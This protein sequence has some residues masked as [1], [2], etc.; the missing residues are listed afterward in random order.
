[1]TKDK[2]QFLLLVVRAVA[3][4]LICNGCGHTEWIDNRLNLADRLME[5]RPD[6]A[7]LILDEIKDAH[8]NSNRLKARYAL[9]KSMALDKNYIDTTT[10]DILQ[11]AID[12]YLRSGN[13]DEKLR[14]LYYQGRIHDNAGNDDLAMQSYLEASEISD[15]VTDSL[16]LARM[17]VAQGIEYYKQYKIN[18]F[19]NTN[20]R[21]ALIYGRI[22]RISQQLQCYSRAINGT[23]ILNDKME[24]DSILNLCKSISQNN[25]TLNKSM[26]RT[27]LVYFVQFGNDEEIKNVLSEIKKEDYDEGMTMNLAMAYSKIGEPEVGMDYLEEAQVFLYDM[28]DSLSYWSVRTVIEEQLGKEGSALESF[29]NYSSLLEKYHLRL[30]SNELLFSEKK[31]AMEIENMAKLHKRDQVI[32][33]ILAGAAFLLLVSVLLYYRYRM[34][35]AARLIAERN[36]EKLKL[37]TDNLRLEGENQ[38]LQTERLESEGRELR[39]KNEN[40]RL[41]IGELEGEREQLKE[42]LDKQETLSEEA[43]MVVRERIEMLNG[44]F[45]QALTNEE[46]YGREFQKYVER[47]KKDK[48]KFQASVGKALEATHPSFMAYLKEHGLTEREIDYVCLYAIGL[49]GKEIGNYLDLARHYNISTEVRRKLGLDTNGENLGPFIRKQMSGE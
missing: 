5:S 18:D 17:F 7:L 19:V 11:P 49:R 26:L 44:L 35:K 15:C 27:F 33:W 2:F 10:F 39:L 30:F 22:G 6:S 12:Y 3:A 31:H 43:R 4:I 48:K 34:N 8:L 16:T 21:S 36:S 9:L 42:L 13:A 14:T 29:R 40:L 24:A 41:Q 1:M 28:L 45:A 20:M 46:K 37:E 32:K 38:R 25:Q 47:I 23:I